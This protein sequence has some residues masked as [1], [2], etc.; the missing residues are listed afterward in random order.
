V[1]ASL[2]QLYLWRAL[3]VKAGLIAE[4]VL[5]EMAERVTQ[6]I[7]SPTWLHEAAQ[8]CASF[9]GNENPDSAMLGWIKM[10]G[11]EG[12]TGPLGRGLREVGNTKLVSTVFPVPEGRAALIARLVVLAGAP[13]SQ[14]QTALRKV[15]AALWQLEEKDVLASTLY[16]MAQP[17][18]CN[19]LVTT[20]PTSSQLVAV[21]FTSVINE[22]AVD[23]KVLEVDQRVQRVQ[24]AY[25]S[26]LEKQRALE[27]VHPPA[28][29]ASAL[30]A[31]VAPAAAPQPPEQAVT[32]AELNAAVIAAVTTAMNQVQ[33]QVKAHGTAERNYAR[34]GARKE[35]GQRGGSGNA[36]RGGGQEGAPRT[37][38]RCGQIGHLKV[39]CP[40]KDR[41]LQKY[42]GRISS[43][44]LAAVAEGVGAAWSGASQLRAPAVV[45]ARPSAEP[46]EVNALIDTGAPLSAID[47]AQ[48]R[49][50][51]CV[52]APYK[53][54]RLATLT[55]SPIQAVGQTSVHVQLDGFS[56]FFGPIAVVA[57]LAWPLL[58]GIKEMAATGA[59]QVD[60]SRS[61]PDVRVG[62]AAVES[63]AR[64][65]TLAAQ[66][67]RSMEGV[68]EL[69]VASR[70]ASDV[71]CARLEQERAERPQAVRVPPE[72][73][74]DV[75]SKLEPAIAFDSPAEVRYRAEYHFHFR[76]AYKQVRY[77]E[78][79][80]PDQVSELK[81][82]VYKYRK[83]FALKEP[84]WKPPVMDMSQPGVS[85]QAFYLRP[86]VQVRSAPQRPYDSR[87]D[88]ARLQ[89][90]AETYLR[91]G[92]GK[93]AGTTAW[94]I[95][96]SFVV[97]GD[98]VVHAFHD[99]NA[100]LL[101][102]AHT[103]ESTDR[104]VRRLAAA[105]ARF[106]NKWDAR[107]GFSQWSL[108]LGAG[109]AACIC[110]GGHIIEP[111]VAQ[112]GIHSTPG[113]YN[114]LMGEIFRP[115]AD[116]F[117]RWPLLERVTS[118]TFMD[119]TAQAMPDFE[120][121]KQGTEFFLARCE[122]Y[123]VTLTASKC[124]I[125]LPQVEHCGVNVQGRV[126]SASSDYTKIMLDFGQ[127]QTRE[128]LVSFL[129]M[130]GWV[131]PFVSDVFE[132]VAVLRQLL[133]TA[134]RSNKASLQW[135]QAAR[136]A[137]RRLREALAHPGV[138]Y[139]FDDQRTL[140]MLTDASN[141]SGACIFM[142]LFEDERGEPILRIVD[143]VCHNFAPA[144]LNYTTPE[145]LAALRAG[146]QRRAHLVLGRA[147]VW[148]S[149]NTAVVELLRS[150]RVSGKKRLRTTWAD[151]A[152]TRLI[153]VHVAGKLNVLADALSRNPALQNLAP[154]DEEAAVQ[155]SAVQLETP[156]VVI[157]AFRPS[158]KTATELRREAASLALG[159]VR[160]AA[161]EL[162][163]QAAELQLADDS[164]KR[165]WEAAATGATWRGLL[166]EHIG[167]AA[168][169]ERWLL[170]QVPRAPGEQAAA[171]R[172]M[173]FV[174][175]KG[176]RGPVLE[177][178]HAA[179]A[180]GAIA[181]FLKALQRTF[182]WP[183]LP[184]DAA[185]FLEAC[186]A[187][188]RAERAMANGT[189]GDSER[190]DLIKPQRP[191]DVWE[192]DEYEWTLPTGDKIIV[193]GAVDKYTGFTHLHF[194]S[195]KK[196]ASAADCARQLHDAY[197]PFRAVHHDGGPAYYGEF[198]RLVERLG[199]SQ[200][201]GSPG[202]SNSQAMIENRFRQLNRLFANMLTHN[203][204][205]RIDPQ[206]AVSAAAQA[207]N[208]TWSRPLQGAPSSTPFERFFGRPPPFS[209]LLAATATP[210]GDERSAVAQF[211]VA[212]AN[213]ATVTEG[214]PRPESAQARAVR[215]AAQVAASQRSAE[216]AH[217]PPIQVALGDLVFLVNPSPPMGKI[218]NRVRSRLG[219]FRVVQLLPAP[220]AA[221]LKARIQLLGERAEELT[222]FL[223]DL[224]QCGPALTV[225]DPVLRALPPSGYFVAELDASEEAPVRAQLQAI[226]DQAL[227]PEQR[228]LVQRERAVWQRRLIAEEE[229]VQMNLSDDEDDEDRVEDNISDS[230]V[231]SD[232]DD[233][234]VS[235][236]DN[237]SNSDEMRDDSEENKSDPE[238]EP[239]EAAPASGRSKR[240]R[241]RPA[242]LEGFVGVP[243]F[244]GS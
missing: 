141:L 15:L 119:D 198:E 204:G 6:H 158:F 153:A 232:S 156:G 137:F 241:R 223:R 72:I 33:Y 244:G 230:D 237:E 56:G 26:L 149:D 183:S 138:L 60:F 58:L 85:P 46:R 155:I 142:Q 43:I 165:A 139:A 106:Y 129:G 152:G 36:G 234:S 2:V 37:C 194:Q 118:C 54:P 49:S 42:D 19:F 140:F 4:T 7:P 218:S 238:P 135:T 154:V 25:D 111:Q 120:E 104:Q 86:G 8:A 199:A 125:G 77:G 44:R 128:Q 217:G 27:E 95:A 88:T 231:D 236:D 174:V 109:A 116:D 143:A 215:R 148:L 162:L 45:R 12:A 92:R 110:V 124:G 16:A 220:P 102:T 134:G 208:S 205:L 39:S 200:S 51:G 78:Q 185:A 65:A 180:H 186:D 123:G 121:L 59:L 240:Q 196:A 64:V 28:A 212:L 150:A 166:F 22:L 176:L 133:K 197:G 182:W 52:V 211:V 67:V 171:Q 224:Q 172:R 79:L 20:L 242:K 233:D 23:K 210:A 89:E 214:P 41:D 159:R 17:A 130:V 32:R 83:C 94:S 175:P 127:P 207:L 167:D 243:N 151:L 219:P 164:L 81:H 69:R 225:D 14:A 191:G 50:L 179:T 221:P 113:G 189:V 74:A 97:N 90:E 115:T 47:A 13:A 35:A 98:R 53:G 11:A 192:L 96:N 145:E 1:V 136:D 181:R 75:Q 80:L 209:L 235:D 201:R 213:E 70:L 188:K 101:S 34:Q 48:A 131:Q 193:N 93:P 187:C 30:I 117:K 99:A 40:V 71:D 24:E 161:P 202:N 160:R 68:P 144:E 112:M 132:D 163:V 147:I 100:M 31:A 55:G 107:E 5:S 170:A 195:D 190:D 157:A 105:F 73:A 177:V 114:R 66:P 91:T 216:A 228:Q 18:Y 10:F 206:D 62:P 57:D 122:Q 168:N 184:G 63:T 227:S 178:M 76:D 108:A 146:C 173:V 61:P 229:K 239:P 226:V 84:G 126:I 29:S 3:L 82:I 103:L 169:D 203:P 87:G 38:Y 222:V 9:Q 21:H